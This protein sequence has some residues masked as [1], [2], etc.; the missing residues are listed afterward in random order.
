MV[1]IES[2]TF[3]LLIVDVAKVE[4]HSYENEITSYPVEVGADKTDHIRPLQSVLTIDGIVSDS[5]IGILTDDGAPS[6]SQEAR[7]RLEELHASREPVSVGTSLRRWDSMALERLSIVRDESSGKALRFTATFRQ[8]EIVTNERASKRVSLPG[9]ASEVDRGAVSSPQGPA[10]DE[11]SGTSDLVADPKRQVPTAFQGDSRSTMR[12]E[13]L[14][15]HPNGVV[16]P[17]S[18][19]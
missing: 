14:R 4:Q 16:G 19:F 11:V 17:V 15:A 1:T 9:A 13:W 2:D 8:I 18:P 5:P 12:T 7:A 6:R 10:L 3:A